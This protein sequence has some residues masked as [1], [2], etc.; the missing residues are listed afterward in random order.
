MGD[1]LQPEH[2]P[3]HANLERTGVALV[4]VGG[5][6]GGGGT[7]VVVRSYLSWFVFVSNMDEVLARTFAHHTEREVPIC[8]SDQSAI[9]K[10]SSSGA[11]VWRRSINT[12]NKGHTCFL[13]SLKDLGEPR[14]VRCIRNSLK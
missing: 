11:R 10:L 8:T 14:T 4:C 5:V 2:H 12:P 7:L 6:G 9:L 1:S 13:S 3:E